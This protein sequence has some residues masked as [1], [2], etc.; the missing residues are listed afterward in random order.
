M[1]EPILP[2][3]KLLCAGL[4]MVVL[5]QIAGLL[6]EE[7]PLEGVRIPNVSTL[8][9]VETDTDSDTDLNANPG[10]GEGNG[11]DPSSRAASPGQ[12]PGSLPSEVLARSEHIM[13]SEIFGALP[14]PPPMALL[15]IAGNKAFLRDDNGRTDIVSEGETLGGLKLLRIGTNRVLV[16]HD[17]EIKEL[18]I[19]SG[20][21]SQ[22]LL[23]NE[24]ENPK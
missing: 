22:T 7:N 16:E 17:G 1:P 9:E 21:G 18:T 5:I 10:A 13:K 12:G 19:F 14:K 2:A 3:L 24:K 4:A 20:F 8:S 23:S 11:R 6:A 15:G